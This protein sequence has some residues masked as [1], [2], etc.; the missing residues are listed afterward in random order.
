MY[1]GSKQSDFGR[2]NEIV[3]PR[4][5]RLVLGSV[6]IVVQAILTRYVASGATRANSVSYPQWDGE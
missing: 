5:A 4:R 3:D 2:T 1:F 6:T